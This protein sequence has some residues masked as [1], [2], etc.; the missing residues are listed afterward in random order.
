MLAVAAA[1]TLVACGGNETKT[2]AT[3]AAETTEQTAE[4]PA[5]E[6]AEVTE[7]AAEVTEE[8]PAEEAPA[9]EA[10]PEAAK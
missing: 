2:E 5:T 6:A 7:E 1:T 10:P 9:T 8:A 3:P 4:Q